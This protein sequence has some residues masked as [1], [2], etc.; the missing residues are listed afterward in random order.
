M[1]GHV[2]YTLDQD[3]LVDEIDWLTCA[4]E[5]KRPEPEPLNES[6]LRGF[7]KY[8]VYGFPA[9]TLTYL[10]ILFSTL[11]HSSS[12]TFCSGNSS[13]CR[14]CPLFAD[15]SSGQVLCQT[16]YR[17]V[18]SLCVDDDQAGIAISTTI[19]ALRMQAGDYLC[20]SAVR[21]WLSFDEIES[22]ILPLDPNGS[23]SLLSATTE[24]LLTNGSGIQMRRFGNTMLFVSSQY[25]LSFQCQCIAAF[26][27][28]V[29]IFV[30]LAIGFFVA[31]NVQ[32]RILK[33]R[34]GN[35][36]VCEIVG[37]AIAEIKARNGAELSSIQL[38]AKLE[39]S[40]GTLGNWDA[41]DQRLRRS[42]WLC[43][44]SDASGTYY[45]LR[46]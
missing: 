6:R 32:S 19:S 10:V 46:R 14:T 28:T 45:S 44:R 31:R 35:G 20:R 37:A 27:K 43:V 29:M 38:K 18:N 26:K 30:V 7:L 12:P 13:S 9:F 17:E 1:G 23:L 24:Y 21:D 34:S 3:G 25:D 22:L 8:L 15:C 2:D 16:G 4:E 40:R 33:A 36:L 42:P 5:R 41:V 39:K 11:S